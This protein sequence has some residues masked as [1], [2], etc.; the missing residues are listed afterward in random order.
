M[1]GFDISI[2]DLDMDQCEDL[3]K[4]FIKKPRFRDDPMAGFFATML[5]MNAAFAKTMIETI[6]E[7]EAAR[8]LL[9]LGPVAIAA[10]KKFGAIEHRHDTRN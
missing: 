10:A 1:S 4:K 7:T 3:I 8:Q 5:A 6:G 2:T 9:D